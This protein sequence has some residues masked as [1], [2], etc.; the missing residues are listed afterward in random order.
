M[1]LPRNDKIRSAGAAGSGH[2]IKV[3]VCSFS[4]RMLCCA[5]RVS[6]GSNSSARCCLGTSQQLYQRW[7]VSSS[8][9]I[10]KIRWKSKL[11]CFSNYHANW[12]MCAELLFE[13]LQTPEAPNAT[14]PTAGDTRCFRG[15]NPQ[16]RLAGCPHSHLEMATL[17]TWKIARALQG[18]VQRAVLASMTSLIAKKTL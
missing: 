13:N 17:T 16:V 6:P 14:S 1:A 8:D 15:S 12:K 18:C 10:V 7:R 4:M 9:P 2:P 11:R 3:P 5:T